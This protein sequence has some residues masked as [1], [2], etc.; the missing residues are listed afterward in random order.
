MVNSSNE[1]FLALFTLVVNLTDSLLKLILAILALK[2]H[3][4]L[5]GCNTGVFP[6]NLLLSTSLSQRRTQP[7]N[8]QYGIFQLCEERIRYVLMY[9]Y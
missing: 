6:K 9:S 1:L 8:C 5:Y 3:Q 7:R 4:D 2:G